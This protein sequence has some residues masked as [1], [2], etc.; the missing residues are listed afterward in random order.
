VVGEGGGVGG[1]G[2]SGGWGEGEPAVGLGVG[3]LRELSQYWLPVVLFLFHLILWTIYLVSYPYFPNTEPPDAVW[4]AEITLSVLHGVFT[5]P[6]GPAGFAG[7]AHILF[8]FISAYFGVGVIFAER[9]T[10][11]FVE[12]LSVLVA[13]CLFHRILPSNRAADYASVAFA[14]IVPAGFFYYSNL[15]R[16]LTSSETFSY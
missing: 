4:H 16:T 15:G 1:G 6:I 2:G 10:A 12:S 5:T 11:A 9:A 7:G 13:Y 8:A 3:K 14:V